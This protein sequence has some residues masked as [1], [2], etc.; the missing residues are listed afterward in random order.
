MLTLAVVGYSYILTALTFF[1]LICDLSIHDKQSNNTDIS[2][3]KL[4][5][6]QIVSEDIYGSC[7]LAIE[8]ITRYGSH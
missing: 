6:D 5:V 8:G 7:F 3:T 4:Q 1:F 2:G